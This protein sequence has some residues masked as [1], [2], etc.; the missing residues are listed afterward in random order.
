MMG[1]SVLS[2]STRTAHSRVERSVA[3][4]TSTSQYTI[5]SA[6]SADG[7]TIGYRQIGSGLGAILL[8]GGYLAAQHYMQLAG[9]LSG[10]F[11]VYVPDRR[12]RGLSGPHGDRY[13]MARECEDADVLLTKTGAHFVWG[14]SSGGLIAL[15]AA[16]MLPSVRKVA[17]YEPPLSQHGS[18]ST[19][20]IPRF[21]REVAQGKPA[22]ALVTFV[23]A[24]NLVPAFLPRWLLV[25][26]V[27]LY[28][29]WEKR[30]V[31][32]PG[33]PM[34]ELI[35]LQRFDGLLVKEMDSSLGSF[36]RMSADVLLMGGQ[37]SPAFLREILDALEETLPRSR[38]VE[39]RGV[40]HGAPMDRGAS[41][42]VGKE[43][44]A[45]FAGPDEFSDGE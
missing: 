12:G 30:R 9:A 31:E 14:H 33:V 27:A 29:R 4:S 22:S 41:E 18:I 5:G 36:A 28:L 2:L 37:K 25:P 20:W 6:T 8:G 24:D 38:R 7:T 32:P 19:S 16:L 13:C 26:L 42:R 40:G 21:D 43:L 39:F 17:V 45:F 15:Q 10:A 11:T 3:L 1:G 35:P 44:R 23:K 34:E